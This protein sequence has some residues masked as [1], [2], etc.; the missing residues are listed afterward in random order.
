MKGTVALAAKLVPATIK[1]HDKAIA[2]NERR[3]LA[4]ASAAG[5]SFPAEPATRGTRSA[6]EPL[7]AEA[8]RVAEAATD[9]EKQRSTGEAGVKANADRA[10]Q[11]AVLSK[12]P[13]QRV[14][15]HDADDD[16]GGRSRESGKGGDTSHPGTSE[17]REESTKVVAALQPAH[18]GTEQDAEKSH[19]SPAREL[20]YTSVKS[21]SKSS[22]SEF[23]KRWKAV[24]EEKDLDSFL[25]MYHANCRVSGLAMEEFQKS[26]RRYFGRYDTIRVQIAKLKIK[27]ARDRF[28]VKFLQSFQG[29]KYRDKG[30]KHLVLV[31]G[32]E[33]KLQILREKWT[34][35]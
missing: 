16:K 8:D 26:K 5:P 24:W 35:Q 22:V 27:K 6:S 32:K 3:R 15:A 11:S 12:N 29:D 10:S 34:P 21:I 7:R 23:L 30:W 28:L 17:E 2:F 9:H 1:L 33:R 20:N 13:T 14:A 19:D 4:V 31:A 25:K 18:A